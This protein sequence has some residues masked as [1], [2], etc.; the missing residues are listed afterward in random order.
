M[1]LYN[2]GDFRGDEI[3]R[4]KINNTYCLAIAYSNNT[5]ASPHSPIVST[6]THD[7]YSCFASTV[8]LSSPFLVLPLILVLLLAF[9]V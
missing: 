6:N 8:A 7:Y 1:R 4:K 5:N 3:I 9:T 2:T